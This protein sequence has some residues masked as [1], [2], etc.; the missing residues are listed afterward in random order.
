M[1]SNSISL[2][3]SMPSHLG[4]ETQS[5]TQSREDSGF[6]TPDILGENDQNDPKENSFSCENRFTHASADIMMKMDIKCQFKTNKNSEFQIHQK[7][8]PLRYRSKM[9]DSN[10]AY[11]SKFV[12]SFA[13]ELKFCDYLGKS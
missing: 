1:E 4:S 2:N 12:W 9:A 5:S 3:S 7:K 8:C 10:P 13:K 11:L 6:R